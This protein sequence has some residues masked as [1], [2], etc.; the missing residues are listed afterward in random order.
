MLKQSI[1]LHNKMAANLTFYFFFTHRPLRSSE[2]PFDAKQVHSAIFFYNLHK[3]TCLSMML[4]VKENLASG[5]IK[6]NSCTV[7]QYEP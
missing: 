4:K 2:F 6:V 7:E 5:G 1:R 3:S